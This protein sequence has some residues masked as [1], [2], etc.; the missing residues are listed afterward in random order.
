MWDLKLIHT[1][2]RGHRV[3]INVQIMV[4]HH[5]F[6]SKPLPKPMMTFP[7]KALQ[8]H[9]QFYQMGLEISLTK[10]GLGLCV[11]VL[12]VCMQQL[13]PL[14]HLVR[15]ALFCYRFLISNSIVK[16]MARSLIYYGSNST[17]LSMKIKPMSINHWR[18]HCNHPIMCQNV[19]QN[20]TKHMVKL[21]I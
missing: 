1:S 5:I 7:L 21:L 6:A 8:Y 3:I 14:C 16:I 15:H 18:K 20:Q 10:M 2:K 11:G 4:C 9:F 17:Q 12:H 13:A 19:Y